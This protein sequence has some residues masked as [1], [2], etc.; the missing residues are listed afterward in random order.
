[1]V[2]AASSDWPEDFVMALVEMH[3][4]LTPVLDEHL[5]DHNELL[6]HMLMGDVV[7]FLTAIYANPREA[8]GDYNTITEIMLSIGDH[9]TSASPAVK[10]VI[11]ASF[12]ENM[13]YP[14]E[15][16]VDLIK[17]LPDNLQAELTKQRGDPGG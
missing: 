13:P 17:L 9:F 4:Q 15:E 6:P 16:G 14:K 1:M 5:K 11:A 10:E 8:A 7:R 12:L 2:L 3:T